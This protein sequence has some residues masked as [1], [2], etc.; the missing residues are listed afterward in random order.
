[1]LEA[2][3]TK[4]FILL[5]DGKIAL[6]K[7]FGSHTRATP[8]YWASAGKTLTAFMVGIA[9]EESDLS[10]SGVDRYDLS[11]ISGVKGGYEQHIRFFIDIG[12]NGIAVFAKTFGQIARDRLHPYKI[13]IKER[14]LTFF[15]QKNGLQFQIRR[16]WLRDS[17][18]CIRMSAKWKDA[19]GVFSVL[20]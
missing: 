8:W 14:R 7:Y 3:N 10:I 13:N 15:L 18:A 6:E 19:C 17:K 11:H 1:M 5:K 4:A 20:Y 9:V 2:E 12:K 16:L